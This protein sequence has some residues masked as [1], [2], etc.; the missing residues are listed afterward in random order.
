MPAVERLLAQHGLTASDIDLWEINE[1]FSVVPLFAI[2]ML[3]LDINRVN[4][5]GGALA[6]GH[7][8]GATG[9]RLVGTL[10]RN[11]ERS[12]KRYGIAAAC[13]GGGQGIAMLIERPAQMF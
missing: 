7:P 2:Q 9:I 11:L 8:L 12:E 10:A 1:A 6:L 5:N 3:G 13:I 4:V